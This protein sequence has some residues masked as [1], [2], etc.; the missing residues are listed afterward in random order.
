MVSGD[1]SRYF[2]RARPKKNEKP[3]MK[4]LRDELRST[5]CRFEM[6]TAVIMPIELQLKFV[7]DF[8]CN[9]IY[10]FYRYCL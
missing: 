3:M 8:N 9:G 5:N 10:H 1:S 2:G 4:R 6:P 7:I